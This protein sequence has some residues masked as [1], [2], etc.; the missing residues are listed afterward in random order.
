MFLYTTAN[1]AEIF[2]DTTNTEYDCRKLHNSYIQ[3]TVCNGKFTVCRLISTN[4]KEYLDP[5]F[6]PGS[7]LKDRV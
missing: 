5:R 6:S 1:I 2:P 7:F 4:P 3:G